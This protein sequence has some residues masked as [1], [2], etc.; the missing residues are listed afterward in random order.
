MGYKDIVAG[1]KIAKPLALR[2]VKSPKTGTPGIE[3]SFEFEEPS[4]GSIERLN[5][6]GWLTKAAIGHTM[7]TLVEVLEYNGSKTTDANGVLT[8]P[9]VINFNKEVKLVIEL[10]ANPEDQKM[11]PK[12]KWVN[13]LGGSAYVGLTPES[14][15]SDLASLGF[16]AA[17]QE[18][19]T[20]VKQS[21]KKL[22][23]QQTPP[24]AKKDSGG[25]RA[26]LPF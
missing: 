5:W 4:V 20:E 18:A 15:K 3:V 6:V 16:D 9:K 21:G 23:D 11:H 1:D 24:P 10:E 13:N 17:F 22:G 19:K 8:D 26:K 14:V 2:F 12:I 7:K 25:L